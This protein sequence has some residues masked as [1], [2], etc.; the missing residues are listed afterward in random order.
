MSNYQLV[1]EDCSMQLAIRTLVIIDFSILFY[2]IWK[3]PD[4]VTGFFN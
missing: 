3:I 1:K 2:V 4:E